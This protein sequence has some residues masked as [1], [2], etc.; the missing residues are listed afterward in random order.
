VTGFMSAARPLLPREVAK[1]L[2]PYYVYILRYPL[3]WNT[4]FYVGKG[5]G[6]RLLQHGL[7][8]ES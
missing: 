5:T 7:V 3:R 8:A 1:R 2:G 6:D 4:P